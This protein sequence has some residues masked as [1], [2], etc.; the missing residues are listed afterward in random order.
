MKYK[1]KD[2]TCGS[3]QSIKSLTDDKRKAKQHSALKYQELH[4]QKKT[5]KPARGEIKWM[6][7]DKFEEYRARQ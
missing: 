2:K 3:H 1:K 4:L 6:N 7:C 5:R